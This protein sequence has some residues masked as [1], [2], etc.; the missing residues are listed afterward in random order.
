M[1]ERFVARTIGLDAS[2]QPLVDADIAA[3]VRRLSRVDAGPSA[4]N[5]FAGRSGGARIRRRN[6]ELY[7]S[8]MRARAPHTL[9]LGEAPGYRGMRITGVPFTNRTI[10]TSGTAAFGLFGASLTA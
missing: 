5:P 10:L 8:A 2:G 7:L 3:Y 9:L 1:P 4:F 6:L